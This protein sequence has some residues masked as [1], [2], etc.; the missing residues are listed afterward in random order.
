MHILTDADVQ[1]RLQPSDAVA[2]IE[3]ALRLHSAGR[4]EAPPRLSAPFADGRLTITAGR[5]ADGW[6]GFRSYDTFDTPQDDQLV[7]AYDVRTG[8]LEGVCIGS[9]LGAARTGAIGANAVKHMCGGGERPLRVGVLG[10]GR[11]AWSQLWA[12]SGVCEVESVRIFS[13]RAASRSALAERC[14]RE[15]S[16]PA[17]AVDSARSAVRDA[18]VA[19]VATTSSEPVF[20]CA[21]LRPDVRVVTVGP[22][23]QGRCEFPPDLI[24]DADLVL[25]DS[26]AQLHSYAPPAVALGY[27]DVPIVELGSAVVEGIRTSGRSVLL[28]VGLSGTEVHLLGRWCQQLSQAPKKSAS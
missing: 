18:D 5:S 22:K 1:N 21:W 19:I 11:Q 8:A 16:L 26:R 10:A 7:T 27:P 28:S 4:L 20:D 24:T 6:F 12:L 13:P 9:A 15:L 2:W 14:H 23:Q 17:I 3:Q 25:T